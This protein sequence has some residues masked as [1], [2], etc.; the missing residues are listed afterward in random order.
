MVV[1]IDVERAIALIR[2]HFSA[3]RSEK[4]AGLEVAPECV[5]VA[6]CLHGV[7][8]TSKPTQSMD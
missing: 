8:I 3:A 4:S 6:V 1:T 7:H 5:Q 2:T